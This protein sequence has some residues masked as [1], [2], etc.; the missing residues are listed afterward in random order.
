MMSTV[1]NAKGPGHMY[2]TVTLVMSQSVA[3]EWSMVYYSYTIV[4]YHLHT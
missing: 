2:S 4:T 1:D 3:P